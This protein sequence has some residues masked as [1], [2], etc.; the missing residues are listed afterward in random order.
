MQVHRQC[1]FESGRTHPLVAG[2]CVYQ[3]FAGACE[4]TP[5]YVSLGLRYPAGT[6]YGFLPALWQSQ[7]V[8][9]TQQLGC[10]VPAIAVC[11][12]ILQKNTS[13]QALGQTE[14]QSVAVTTSSGKLRRPCPA[15]E[16]AQEDM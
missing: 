2:R 3:G 8:H 4:H 16:R 7:R 12:T 14:A 15:R 11:D 1:G 13:V 9:V 10:N 6:G 5:G